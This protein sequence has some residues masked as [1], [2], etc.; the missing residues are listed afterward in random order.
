MHRPPV[1]ERF[2]VVVEGKN[3]FEIPQ[4]EAR[5]RSVADQIARHAVEL[6]ACIVAETFLAQL[7][8]LHEAFQE[9]AAAE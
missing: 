6:D 2:V 8:Q 5:D 9:S 1:E 7:A 3:I 4:P